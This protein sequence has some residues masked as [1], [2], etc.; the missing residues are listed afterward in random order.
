MLTMESKSFFLQFNFLPSSIYDLKTDESDPS[1][2]SVSQK[3][4][5]HQTYTKFLQHTQY[6]VNYKYL[7][8]FKMTNMY[9]LDHSC[10]TGYLRNYDPIKQY[11]CLLPKNNTSRPLIVPQEYLIHFDNFL[12][13]LRPMTKIKHIIQLSTNR[14]T[15]IMNFYLL[16]PK[17][18]R[19]WY[20]LN[21]NQNTNYL[22]HQ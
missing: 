15:P 17:Q 6:F 3:A 9:T 16:Q 18:F 8:P 20:N 5:H 2:L 13:V 1:F 10:I 11:Y 14:H 22:P 21:K 4:T 19:L 7:S 12:S